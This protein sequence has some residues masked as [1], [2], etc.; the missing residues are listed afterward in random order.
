MTPARSK[1]AIALACGCFYACETLISAELRGVPEAVNRGRGANS[2]SSPPFENQLR[3]F[4]GD[5][6][7]TEFVIEPL[8]RPVMGE[9]PQARRQTEL[10]RLFQRRSQ[11]YRADA[12]TLRLR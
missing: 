10:P 1:P 9:R 6:S 4:F 5:D 3:R 7:K 12:K 11:H 8:R 2:R